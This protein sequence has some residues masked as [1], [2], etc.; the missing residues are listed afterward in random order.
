MGDDPALEHAL[1]EHLQF[2]P[3]T[4]AELVRRTAA[5]DGRVQVALDEL[6]QGTYVVRRPQDAGPADYEITAAGCGR[7]DLIDDF[8]ESPL[9]VMGKLFAAGIRALLARTFRGSDRRR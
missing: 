3:L 7:L 8:T 6:V 2:T 9:K 5:D 1:L 4:R